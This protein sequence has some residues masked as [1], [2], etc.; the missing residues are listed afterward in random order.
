MKNKA[1]EQE[2]NEDDQQE[3]GP[4]AIELLREDHQKVQDLFE[5]FESA[6]N[7]SRQRIVDQA[8]MELEIHSKLEEGLIYPAIRDALDEEDMMDEALEEHHVVE[9]LIK[10]LR[11]MGPK[12]ER[13]KAKFTVLA[14]IVKH[15]IEEEESE[16][17]PQAEE[18]DIDMA[19][20]GQEAMA[21]KE[22]LMSKMHSGSSS[23]KKPSGSSKSGKSRKRKA[24]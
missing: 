13:Y 6:D 2:L 15:H 12:D 1:D 22:K 5:E 7:R 8:L 16:V 19:E 24:A 10:E 20:L 21:L 23:K 3:D 17:L 18:T 14:E 9:L 11:K 4:S